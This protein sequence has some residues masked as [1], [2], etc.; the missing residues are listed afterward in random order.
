MKLH[1]L[2]NRTRHVTIISAYAPTLAFLDKV[3]EQLYEDPGHLIKATLPSDKLITLEDFNV[4]VSKVSND[5]NGVL[6]P[7]GGGNLNSSGLLLLS[8]CAKQMLCISSAVFHQV[9]KYKTNWM[10]PRSSIGT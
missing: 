3:K 6:G 9:D 8:K 2:L 1:F 10:H 4:S 5:W 7:Q